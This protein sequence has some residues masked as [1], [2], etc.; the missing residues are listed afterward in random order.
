MG[1]SSTDAW[2]TAKAD[3]YQMLNHTIADAQSTGGVLVCDDC[4]EP[5]KQIGGAGKVMALKTMGYAKK[6]DYSVLCVQCHNSKTWKGYVSGHSRHVDSVKA[7]CSWCHTFS[8][9]ERGLTMP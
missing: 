8:R 5:T 1:F 7:D 9:P 2:D 4:H 3:T 6:A